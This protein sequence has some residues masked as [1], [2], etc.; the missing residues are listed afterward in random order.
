MFVIRMQKSRY[1]CATISLLVCT[2]PVISVQYS[3]YSC[4]IISLFVCDNC[5]M[6]KMTYVILFCVSF[7]IVCHKSMK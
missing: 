4:A 3:C 1:S 6:D 7:P 2:I 5:I